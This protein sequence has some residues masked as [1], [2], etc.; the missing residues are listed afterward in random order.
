MATDLRILY[1]DEILLI[2]DKPAPLPMHEGGRFS[3][4]T[5]KAFMAQAWPELEVRYAHRLDA[6]T[7]GTLI[8]VKGECYRSVVQKQFESGEVSKRYLAKVRMW[9]R[10]DVGEEHL[11]DI[12]IPRDGRTTGKVVE[13]RT[14]VKVLR[15]DADETTL[16]EVE[17]ITGRT[18]Q[19][20]NHLWQEGYPIVGDRLY[21]PDGA[22]GVP[23]IGDRDSPPL[24]LR[25]WKVTLRHPANGKKMTFQCEERF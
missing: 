16:L 12:P 9:T 10:W 6:E 24:L 20:R 18:H 3:R 5:L 17:P 23:A 11:I 22:Y 1:E 19:I 14:R 7:S 21:L 4:N 8:C 15:H 25:S 13:A 2:I